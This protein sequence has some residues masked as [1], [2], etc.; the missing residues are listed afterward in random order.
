MSAQSH[1]HLGMLLKPNYCFL[2]WWR[3]KTVFKRKN[4]VNKSKIHAENDGS[5]RPAQILHTCFLRVWIIFTD[6]YLEFKKTK[7]ANKQKNN[8][9]KRLSAQPRT[10]E[11]TTQ[12]RK[13]TVAI[14]THM[15]LVVSDGKLFIRVQRAETS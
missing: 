9:R 1:G 8:E 10:K 2:Y 4:K 13:M 11:R 15:S 12:R 7:Q 3:N 6:I 14:C 5:E